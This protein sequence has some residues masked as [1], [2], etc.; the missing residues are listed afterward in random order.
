MPV[1]ALGSARADISDVVLE[2]LL[3]IHPAV[4]T[5]VQARRET[6][7]GA[8][9]KNEHQCFASHVRMP[10]LQRKGPKPRPKG[11]DS[12]ISARILRCR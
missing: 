3:A 10:L 5:A 2:R 9:R 1:R 4:V 11:P 8:D 6:G 7:D 12:M